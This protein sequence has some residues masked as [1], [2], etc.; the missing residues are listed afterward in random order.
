MSTDQ[1][2]V[3]IQSDSEQSLS[4]FSNF[5]AHKKFTIE[6]LPTYSAVITVRDNLRWRKQILKKWLEFY[7]DNIQQFRTRFRRSDDNFL[8]MTE[9]EYFIRVWGKHSWD[10]LSTILNEY[11]IEFDT[12]KSLIEN[13]TSVDSLV[14]NDNIFQVCWKLY[15]M[16]HDQYDDIHIWDKQEYIM[17]MNRCNMLVTINRYGRPWTDTWQGDQDMEVFKQNLQMIEE[18]LAADKSLAHEKLCV[19]IPDAILNDI[20][21]CTDSNFNVDMKK[22]YIKQE[23]NDIHK[24]KD[25]IQKI[26][27]STKRANYICRTLE[28][29]GY[30]FFCEFE[31]Y[32]DTEFK[33]NSDTISYYKNP[34]PYNFWPV[35]VK[36]QRMLTSFSSC[37]ESEFKEK[38]KA[39]NNDQRLGI[40]T[41]RKLLRDLMMT[42]RN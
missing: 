28:E 21:T 25:D 32:S 12:F 29:K 24:T 34:N 8:K 1:Y 35:F 38:I 5:H 4:R 14:N 23:L 33:R 42:R 2:M 16:L 7:D 39:I 27:L 13:V 37:S 36:D 26:K 41:K 18:R 3:H 40:E 22:R 9:R 15:I 19:F 6:L 30:K 10:S 31:H 17:C 11:E 20:Y